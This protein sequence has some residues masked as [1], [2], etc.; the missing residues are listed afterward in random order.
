ML[1]VYPVSANTEVRGGP[2]TLSVG[3][4]L[5][6]GLGEDKALALAAL[7]NLIDG[8]EKARDHI[9]A[10]IA[11]EYQE[12]WRD[13]IDSN[14]PFAAPVAAIAESELRVLDGNR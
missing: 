8:I 10:L 12:S 3:D 6:I 11:A 13:F 14:P 1:V 5:I 2:T 7:G 9:A 4:H